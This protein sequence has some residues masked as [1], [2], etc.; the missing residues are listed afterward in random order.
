MIKNPLVA[1]SLGLGLMSAASFSA[2]ARSLAIS[3]SESQAY[4]LA[5]QLELPSA[6][7]E[8]FIHSVEELNSLTDDAAIDTKVKDL[9]SQAAELRSAEG[10]AYN[11]A[12]ILANKMGAPTTVKTWLQNTVD[13]L[14]APVALSDDAKK[15]ADT[16][17][18]TARILSTLD[19]ATALHEQAVSKDDSI[20]LWLKISGGKNVVWAKEV[21]ALS[22][23]VYVS[24][25]NADGPHHPTP[26][27]RELVNSAPKDTPLD[28]LRALR[29]LAP[30]TDQ[31]GPSDSL[32]LRPEVIQAAYL[33]VTGAF[34]GN[35]P[36][37]KKTDNA[38][39]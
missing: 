10:S 24:I 35:M 2:N 18:A 6:R 26:A 1:I 36:A 23:R 28:V 38:G 3:D 32:V 19:E 8:L 4:Q 13:L 9:D 11:R 29:A 15:E 25:S 16:Q 27:A 31:I 39:A 22:A 33:T 34:I 7:A 37:I 20:S 30:P 5:Y 17:P 21:G 14:E 12:L